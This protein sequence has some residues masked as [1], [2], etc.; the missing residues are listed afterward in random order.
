V[1][2]LAAGILQGQVAELLRP[3]EL[4]EQ[5]TPVAVG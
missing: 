4:G 1:A 5:G 3:G 2:G